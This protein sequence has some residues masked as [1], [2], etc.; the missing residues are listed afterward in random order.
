MPI[1]NVHPEDVEKALPMIN[2]EG[3]QYTSE[4]LLRMLKMD[5]E[6]SFFFVE[7][8]PIAVVTSVTY[9]QTG[10]IGHLVVM[11]DARRRK[12]GQSLLRRAIQYCEGAGARSII[13]YAT[14]EG[15]GLYQKFGFKTKR[16]ALGAQKAWSTDDT[17]TSNSCGL[18]EKEDLGEISAIDSHLFGDDRSKLIRQLYEEFPQHSWKLE[19]NGRSV[20]F[21]MGR[22]T[23]AGCDF[24]PWACLSESNEDA[25]LLM[26]AV[27]H[28]FGESGEFFLGVFSGNA[29]AVEIFNRLPS[30]KEW[31]TKLMVRGADRYVGR[32]EHTFG[33][34]A[35]E[36]G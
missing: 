13:L 12:I 36:L 30:V 32:V 35:F 29:G 11:K 21:A 26:K 10:V 20:G 28:S 16:K 18:I 24:G 7:G 27:L 34:A 25:N 4:E 2:T 19:R 31:T 5:P 17:Q 15:E 22:S 14:D 3:W 23:H 33:V 8:E 9:G 6:G 1:V